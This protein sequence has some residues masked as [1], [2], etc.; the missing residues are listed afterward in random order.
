M[1]EIIERESAHCAWIWLNQDMEFAR[2]IAESTES[3]EDK[4]SQYGLAC[5]AFS[6]PHE[7]AQLTD[8]H[9][10]LDRLGLLTSY[11]LRPTSRYLF[12]ALPPTSDVQSQTLVSFIFAFLASPTLEP[13]RIA[14]IID[15]RCGIG[16]VPWAVGEYETTVSEG[17][18]ML[19][20]SA[21]GRM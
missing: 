20:G 16:S 1:M 15:S 12:L 6:H 18:P 7:D 2:R 19:K 3:G 13:D 17:V 5:I 21:C 9:A 11:S 4:D 10:V 8:I 14:R